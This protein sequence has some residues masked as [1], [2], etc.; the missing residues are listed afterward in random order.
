MIGLY[1]SAGRFFIYL[2]IQASLLLFS[3]ALTLTIGTYSP[4]ENFSQVLGTTIIIIFIIFGGSFSNPNT[5]P[6]WLSWIIWISPIQYGFKAS[7]QNQFDG[8]EFICN[9]NDPRCIESGNDV[10]ILYGMESPSIWPCILTLW[11]LTVFW[12]FIGAI[13][14]LQIVE[15]EKLKKYGLLANKLG[16]IDK[17]SVGI[18][19][20]YHKS[21]LKILQISMNVESKTIFFDRRRGLEGQTPFKTNDN[22]EDDEPTINMD[23]ESNSEEEKSWYKRQKKMHKSGIKTFY[24]ENLLNKS[25]YNLK[26][27]NTI[28]A[29][30]ETKD[31]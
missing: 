18:V 27:L 30:K 11:G 9:D 15:T 24:P 22:K 20:K 25:I 7:M 21:L 16:L 29:N 10:I 19:A 26:N 31:G 4:S 17:F 28:F 2:L 3:I 1:P 8:L 12:I 6:S 14:S 13:D 23:E 5:I